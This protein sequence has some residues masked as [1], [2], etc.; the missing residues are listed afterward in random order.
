MP[1][2]L[3]GRELAL[4]L[5]L[6]ALAC[7]DGRASSAQAQTAPPAVDLDALGP[8]VG[9]ALPDFSLPDQHGVRRSLKSILGP[10]GAVVVFFRSADW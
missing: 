7:A 8:Q 1:K 6:A 4:I 9:D 3:R 10:N 2:G 5:C